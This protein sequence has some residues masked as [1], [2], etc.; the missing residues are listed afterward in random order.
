ME[1]ANYTI[2]VRGKLLYH[3][4]VLGNNGQVLLTSETYYSKGNAL[5]AA[6][7]ASKEFGWDWH[8]K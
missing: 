6:R 3:Y 8:V 1:Q 4:V 2:E 5:R 7:K